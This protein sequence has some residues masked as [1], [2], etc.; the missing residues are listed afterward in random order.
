MLY[1]HA[2]DSYMQIYTGG[3]YYTYK[4]ALAEERERERDECPTDRKPIAGVGHC[5]PGGSVRSEERRSGAEAKRG[6]RVLSTEMTLPRIAR[7][8]LFV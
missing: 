3:T 7:R 5:R 8:E 4:S 1:I 2:E 6:E